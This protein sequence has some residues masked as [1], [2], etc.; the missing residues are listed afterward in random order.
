M[1]QDRERDAFATAFAKLQGWE[2]ASRALQTQPASSRVC[3][4]LLDLAGGEVW[5]AARETV[6]PPR[7]GRSEAATTASVGGGGEGGGGRGRGSDDVTSGSGVGGVALL[8][9]PNA[10]QLLLE[11]LGRC[12]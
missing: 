9:L 4:A 10:L 12:E 8:Q 3:D 6:P 7:V 11:G 1:A 5:G 2:L